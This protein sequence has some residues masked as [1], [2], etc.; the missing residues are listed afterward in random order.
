MLDTRIRGRVGGRGASSCVPPA[1]GGRDDGATLGVGGRGGGT[2]GRGGGS[3]RPGWTFWGVVF[4]ATFAAA[5]CASSWSMTR[6][7]SALRASAEVGAV[8]SAPPRV[9]TGDD[10]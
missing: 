4:F 2:F 6:W 5:A 10:D 9:R 7:T 8:R 1:S 3:A